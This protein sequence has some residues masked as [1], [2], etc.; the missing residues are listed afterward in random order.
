MKKLDVFSLYELIKIL[1]YRI[2][3]LDNEL[4]TLDKDD[5]IFAKKMKKRNDFVKYIDKINEEIDNKVFN[6][7]NSDNK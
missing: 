5:I 2:Q 4:F 1:K 7:L 6:L 3:I